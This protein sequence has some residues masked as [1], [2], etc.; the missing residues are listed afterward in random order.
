M[1]N[2]TL[3]WGV[4]VVVYTVY[5]IVATLPVDLYCTYLAGAGNVP[6]PTRRILYCTYLQRLPVQVGS[7]YRSNVVH[8]TGQ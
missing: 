3:D 7:T 4:R 2:M 1:F 5:Y 6:V 8:E